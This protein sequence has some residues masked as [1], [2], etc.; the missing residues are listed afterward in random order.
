MR[1][2]VVGQAIL[3]PA[4]RL[5]ARVPSTATFAVSRGQFVRCSR[6]VGPIAV[7]DGALAEITMRGRR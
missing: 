2:S 7:G 5:P 1:D 6:R 4:G 3:S